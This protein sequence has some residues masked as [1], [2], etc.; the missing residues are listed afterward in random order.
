MRSKKFPISPGS[1]ATVLVDEGV[2]YGKSLPEGLLWC[3]P[4]FSIQCSCL[5]CRGQEFDTKLT[6][7][8]GC[9]KQS[10]LVGKMTDV[11]SGVFSGV[12][13]CGSTWEGED[14]TGLSYK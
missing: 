4:L 1:I 11:T 8:L 6:V 3:I 5:I 7:N 10:L 9:L 2:D 12:C 13:L 14:C